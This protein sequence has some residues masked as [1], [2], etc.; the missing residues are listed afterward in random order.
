MPHLLAPGLPGST[1]LPTL[2]LIALG[3]RLLSAR[4]PGDM[5]TK[6]DSC[7]KLVEEVLDHLLAVAEAKI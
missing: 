3:K 5:A 2:R 1:S 7:G 6:V 4:G